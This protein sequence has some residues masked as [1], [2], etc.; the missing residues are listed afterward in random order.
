MCFST[1]HEHNKYLILIFYIVAKDKSVTHVY[2]LKACRPTLFYRDTPH[3]NENYVIIFS[4]SSCCKPVWVS[5]FC[6][7]QR[8]IFWRTT[9]TKQLFGTIDFH[10]RTKNYYGSQWCQSFNRSSKYLP[11][12]S[13]L[14]G[15]SL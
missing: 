13:F 10:N 7:T 8:K 1:Q 3:K 6:R 11:I 12:F 5:F 2:S 15:V 14:G 9:G 4:P